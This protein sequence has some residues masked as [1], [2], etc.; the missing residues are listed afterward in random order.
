MA[1]RNCYASSR[2]SL[3][4]QDRDRLAQKVPSCVCEG[5]EK[6][7]FLYFIDVT[8]FLE[9]NLIVCIKPFK[10]EAL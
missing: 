2:P 4:T 5:E 6:P 7:E 8:V 1:S 3:P 9:G 10:S